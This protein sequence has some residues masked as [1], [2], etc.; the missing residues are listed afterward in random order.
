MSKSNVIIL[1]ATVLMCSVSIEIVN[2]MEG[3]MIFLTKD[4][5]V[6]PSPVLT[7]AS[8]MEN[9]NAAA[10]QVPHTEIRTTRPLPILQT[11][12]VPPVNEAFNKPAVGSHTIEPTPKQAPLIEASE[13][14][15]TLEP[16]KAI[17]PTQTVKVAPTKSYEEL[18]RDLIALKQ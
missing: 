11:V 17:A 6:K 8:T 10:V 15:M 1:F 4:I 13:T 16:V 18:L 14:V 7:F 9:I 2:P 3:T 12:L 5:N